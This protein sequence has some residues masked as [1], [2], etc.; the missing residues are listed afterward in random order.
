MSFPSSADPSSQCIKIVLE[1]NC[2]GEIDRYSFFN[3]V[4]IN[5]LYVHF[6]YIGLVCLAVFCHPFRLA[7]S[8]LLSTSVHRQ[9]KSRKAVSRGPTVPFIIPLA[10]SK[11]LL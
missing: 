9:C 2:W 11:T 1:I 4:I 6:I 10:L 3:I 7:L 8:E 5:A